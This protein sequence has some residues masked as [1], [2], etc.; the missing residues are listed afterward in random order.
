MK[1]VPRASS[2]RDRRGRASRR[3]LVSGSAGR[4][5]WP[6]DGDVLRPFAL[7][8]DAYA[9]GQHRGDRR[10]RAGGLAGAGARRRHRDVRRLAA[11]LRPRRHDPHRG[12]LR[13]HARP[14]RLDR[15]REGR[16]GRRGGADRDDGLE[17]RRR[18]TRSRPSTSASGSGVRG[19]GL[20]RPARPAPAAAGPAPAPPPAPAPV[21]AAPRRACRPPSTARPGSA[22]GCR[23]AVARRR[24][25]AAAR[26]DVRG[27]AAGR[28]V[29]A[30]PRRGGARP[31][32]RRPAPAGGPP[33]ADAPATLRTAYDAAARG[34]PRCLAVGDRAVGRP[35]SA[36]A[37]RRST[38]PA[39][40][41]RAA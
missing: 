2:S 10:R 21:P 39:D 29:G 3:S 26:T 35:R 7:G 31:G 8:G 15:R 12:R 14:P 36:R 13:R 41:A 24:R 32:D 25:A 27:T 33:A 18:S 9:A 38:S 1:E 28:G 11:D 23:T 17:R 22:A 16:R 40:D 34:R 20:R 5:S 19:G 30:A 37:E 6:A 4:W